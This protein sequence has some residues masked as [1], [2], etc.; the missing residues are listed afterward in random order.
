MTTVT[1]TVAR[2]RSMAASGAD[3]ALRLVD[4]YAVA[5]P[6]DAAEHEILWLAVEAG[7]LDGFL[8][9]ARDVLLHHAHPWH[10]APVESADQ[11]PL[12]QAAFGQAY[13]VR[14]AVA[15][16]LDEVVAAHAAGDPLN[17]RRT[18]LA[19]GYAQRR[20]G[21][22]VNHV[23]GVLGASSATDRHGLDRYW[24]AVQLLGA[25][26]PAAQLVATGSIPSP[27]GTLA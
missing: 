8:A 15:A 12:S 7:L 11:D 27:E 19:R 18:A 6:D 21:E 22:V 24:R 20:A 4:E 9:L 5:R 3:A 10:E 2:V 16:L 1:E 23:I 14:A 25:E 17:A 13:A 26:H